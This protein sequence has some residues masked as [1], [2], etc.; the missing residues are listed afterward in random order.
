MS[1]E[2]SHAVQANDKKWLLKCL[3]AN[4]LIDIQNIGVMKEPIKGSIPPTMLNQEELHE[5]EKHLR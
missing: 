4:A 1:L 3:M 5:L 2:I